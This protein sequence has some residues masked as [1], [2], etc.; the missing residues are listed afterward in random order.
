MDPELGYKWSQREI[1]TRTSQAQK[2]ME[3]TIDA[4]DEGL[5]LGITSYGVARAHPNFPWNTFSQYGFGSPQLYNLNNVMI[6][7][8]L[9]QWQTHG[10]GHLV[11]SVQAFGAKDEEKLDGYLELYAKPDRPLSHGFIFWSWRQLSALE[12]RVIKKWS[13]YFRTLYWLQ[14]A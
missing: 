12:W 9:T 7:R 8:G 2:L 10:W 11:P 4:M 6:K 1:M 5:N 13:D 3:L 14:E